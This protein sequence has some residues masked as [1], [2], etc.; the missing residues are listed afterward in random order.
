MDRPPDPDLAHVAPFASWLCYFQTATWSTT[1]IYRVTASLEML[2]RHDVLSLPNLFYY[3]RSLLSTRYSLFPFSP[4]IE[5][6]LSKVLQS[7]LAGAKSFS[8]VLRISF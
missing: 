6:F 8:Y 1:H 3:L 4:L 7:L 2:F 5:T